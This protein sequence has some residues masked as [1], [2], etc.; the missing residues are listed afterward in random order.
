M[1]DGRLGNNGV[2]SLIVIS[3]YMLAMSTGQ[4]T[5]IDRLLPLLRSR[6]TEFLG[7]LGYEFSAMVTIMKEERKTRE[8]RTDR[9]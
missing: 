6:W 8:R 3:T 4:K 7:S 5:G 2:H 1:D 9:K